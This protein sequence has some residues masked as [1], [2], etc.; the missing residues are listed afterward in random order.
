MTKIAILETQPARM[1]RA[2]QAG[3]W[4]FDTHGIITAVSAKLEDPRSELCVAL[5]ELIEAWLCREKGITDEEVTMF[6]YMFE[7]ERAEGKHGLTD[8]AGDDHR[9]PYHVQHRLATTLEIIA[10]AILGLPW[11]KHEANVNKLFG[12]ASDSK[13]D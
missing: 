11:E 5:H 1:I 9:A 4:Y 8:E 10:A 13:A 6:D 3:D 12:P 2:D 7:R